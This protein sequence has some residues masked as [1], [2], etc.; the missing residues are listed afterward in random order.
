M[1]NNVLLERQGV[2]GTNY[3]DVAVGQDNGGSLV[4]EHDHVLALSEGRLRPAFELRIERLPL[5]APRLPRIGLHQKVARGGVGSK[6]E[7]RLKR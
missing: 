6:H 4:D 2:A 7:F 5:H 1:R 3:A